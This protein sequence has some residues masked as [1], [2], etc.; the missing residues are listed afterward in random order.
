MTNTHG[1]IA[2]VKRQY[3]KVIAVV[4]VTLLL[5]AIS[6]L[7]LS[8]ARNLTE[9]QDY[10][11]R[12]DALSPANPTLETVSLTLYSNALGHLERPFR[13]S[14]DPSS[15][16]KFFVPESRV[17]CASQSCRALIPRGSTN[18]PVC[19][20]LQPVEPTDDPN[21]D[22]DGGGIPDWWEIKYGLNPSD[23]KDDRIDS[24]GDG[25]DNYA[26]FKANTDPTD[27]KSHPDLIALLRVANIE[28]TPL[29]IKFM[30]AT[31]LPNG[32]TRVQINLWEGNGRQATSY[33]VVEG[34]KIGKTEFKLLRYIET[35]EERFDPMMNKNRIFTIK[36][37]EIGRGLKV[38]TLG[39]DE[40]AIEADYRIKLV[41]TLDGTSFEVAGDGEFR[42]GEKKYRVISVDN[43]AMT[44]VLR[45]DADALDVTVPRL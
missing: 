41:Q 37:V 15:T 27:P 6:T 20:I 42:V 18:C 16:A 29:P 8:R 34:E 5:L 12:L 2:L 13:I 3:D 23:P 24:D 36:K 17:W 39:L 7:M 28:A 14:S 21:Y 4:A 40:N 19:Q 43:Q 1:F 22:S 32:K 10:E 11:R 31:R 45:S 26:E 30:G 44:V 38:T 9:E 25:F 35:T 33:F